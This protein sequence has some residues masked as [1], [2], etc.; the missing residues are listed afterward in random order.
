MVFVVVD[1]LA[2]F[3]II[4]VVIVVILVVMKCPVCRGLKGADIERVVGFIHAA[5]SIA[6]H[7]QA[8]SG[9]KLVDFKVS[10]SISMVRLLI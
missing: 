9:P 8:Q 4:A 1:V 10:V 5:L 3:V 2:A 7:V 6:V